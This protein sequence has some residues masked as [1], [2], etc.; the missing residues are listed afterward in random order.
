MAEAPVLR[1]IIG[2][3]LLWTAAQVLTTGGF[4]SYFALE[5]GSTSS[6]LALVLAVP[7]LSGIFALPVRQVL[8]WL[9]GRKRVC[10]VCGM[11][12]R[13]VMLGIPGLAMAH[14]PGG[15][16]NRV[17]WLVVILACAQGLH[18][19]SLTA[20]LSWLADLVPRA[21]WGRFLATSNISNLVILLLLTI[22]AGYGRQWWKTHYPEWS[23]WAYVVIFGLG[24]LL[25]LLSLLPLLR[26]PDVPTVS[27]AVSRPARLWREILGDHAFRKLLLFQWWFAFWS[28]FTQA[29]FFQYRVGPLKIG[30]GTFYLMEGMMRLLQ[31]PASRQAGQMCDAGSW[32]RALGWGVASSGSA[33]VFWMLATPGQWWWLWGAY[34]LW[35]GWGY[36][37]VAA[38]HAALRFSPRRN[39]ATHLAFLRQVSGVLA[40]LS[41]LLGGWLL[42]FWQRLPGLP[43][44]MG[45]GA[46]ACQILF[47][48]SLA[49]RLSALCWLPRPQEEIASPTL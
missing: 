5:L 18:A 40:G 6:S 16:E 44:L 25:G 48:I 12:S 7:E 31:I 41:G 42:D 10:L 19:I 34:I 24:T 30:L 27:D 15:E 43:A 45:G 49:G 23:L 21:R 36:F 11:L 3:Y 1:R 47:F 20:E 8:S 38:P 33:L 32:R 17:V 39:N 28:G 9:G 46:S 4:L 2:H 29:V 35:G 22:P 26:L 13:F 37:N 14:Q